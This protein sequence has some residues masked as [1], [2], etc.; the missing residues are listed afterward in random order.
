MAFAQVSSSSRIAPPQARLGAYAALNRQ[1][2]ADTQQMQGSFARDSSGDKTS[3]L[4]KFVAETAQ[5]IGL[6]VLPLS[7]DQGLRMVGLGASLG[8]CEAA[9][10]AKA[11]RRA[12][13]VHQGS[14]PRLYGSEADGTADP[15][16]TRPRNSRSPT[17]REAMRLQA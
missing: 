11:E 12:G 2:P 15:L 5:Q 6:R 16:F 4:G 8:A 17:V 9:M 1:S 13:F 7:P 10:A 3:H 14:E